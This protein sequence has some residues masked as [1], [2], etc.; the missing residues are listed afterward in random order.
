MHIDNTRCN[1]NPGLHD[2]LRKTNE[3]HSAAFFATFNTIERA[4]AATLRGFFEV[5]RRVYRRRKTYR[6]LSRLSDRQLKDIGISRSE[7]DGVAQTLAGESPEVGLTI[8]DMRQIWRTTQ[9]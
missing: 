2:H 1:A 8:A 4:I 6:E 3:A 7:I 5:L 9:T